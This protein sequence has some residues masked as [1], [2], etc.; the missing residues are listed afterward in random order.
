ME[1]TKRTRELWY[2]G[3]GRVMGAVMGLERVGIRDNFFDLGGHSLLAVRLTSAIQRELGVNI[4]LVML[5]ANPTIEELALALE[6]KALESM[7]REAHLP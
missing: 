3:R 7:N 6:E 4:G 5:F 1:V 2:Q